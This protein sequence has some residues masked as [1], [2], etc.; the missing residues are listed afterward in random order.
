MVR[1]GI[2]GYFTPIA[3]RER[4]VPG[5]QAE[6]GHDLSSFMEDQAAEIIAGI[7]DT[8]PG[9]CSCEADGA[10]EKLHGLFLEAKDMLD[11]GADY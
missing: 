5:F 7:G 8:D 6:S 4:V 1:T 11:A 3:P 2:W 10:D 9:C